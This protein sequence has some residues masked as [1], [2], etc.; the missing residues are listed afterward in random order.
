MGGAA[1]K[2]G[3]ESFGRSAEGLARRRLEEQGWRVAGQ[4]VRTPAGELDLVAWDGD[5]LVFVEV[6]ARRG[7]P[8]PAEAAVDQAKQR[9]LAEAAGA[10][11]AQLEGAPPVCRFDVV[12][13]EAGGGQP[14]LRHLRD[15]FRLG[16]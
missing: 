5:T 7:G 3:A 6:K 2:R 15:A 8:A 13:V 11:L 16:D 12:A 4:R 10:Y 9:R 1:R 14:R